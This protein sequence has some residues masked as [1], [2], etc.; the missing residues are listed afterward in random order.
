[1]PQPTKGDVHVNRPLTSI[2]IAYVQSQNE[3]IADRVFP[4]IPVASSSDIYFTYDQD[5]WFRSDAAERAPATESE[6]TGYGISQETYATKVFAL[7]HDVPDQ[8]RAN[9]D[10]PLSPDRD[11]T[12]LVTQQMLIK[13][14]TD[15]AAAYF[16]TGL[17]T[18][19]TTGTDIVP[20]TKWDAG[21][22]T[23]MADIRAQMKSVKTKTGFRPNTLVL[24]EDVWVALQDNADVID[25]IKTTSDKVA[26]TAMLAN[27]LG[28]SRVLVAGATNN[29]AAEGQTVSM[30]DVFTDDA[31][32]CYS[33]PR[34]SVMMPSAGY[35]FSW[36]GYLGASQNGLRVKRFRM[37]ELAADRIEIDMAYDQK[38]VGANFGAFFNG[39]LT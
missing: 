5:Q 37:E 1:M 29:T 4:N 23:P 8:V 13:K 9:A 12:M 15:W 35:T 39:C 10:S 34:P 16:T 19:S 26:T 36:T 24:A 20:G 25:R 38:L 6:G 27:H 18:G 3:F 17:W 7:H 28:L 33:A 14:E 30:S 21:S 11:G 22:S 32:L 31:F 2:S